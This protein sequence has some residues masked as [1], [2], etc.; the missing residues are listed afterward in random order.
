MLRHS[1]RYVILLDTL[2][3]DIIPENVMFIE[4]RNTLKYNPTLT[5]GV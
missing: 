4:G 3:D 5:V 1:P 2:F